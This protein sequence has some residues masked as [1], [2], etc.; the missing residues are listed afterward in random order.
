VI[1]RTAA[2]AD[3]PP[4]LGDLYEASLVAAVV[5]GRAGGMAGLYDRTP[6]D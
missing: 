6:G 1:S 5:S 2:D 4:P 3:T